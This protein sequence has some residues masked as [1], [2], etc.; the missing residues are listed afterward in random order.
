MPN[1]K[2]SSFGERERERDLILVGTVS[3]TEK[4]CAVVLYST[5]YSFSS[6]ARRINDKAT[7]T[8]K[9]VYNINFYENNFFIENRCYYWGGNYLLDIILYPSVSNTVQ[10]LVDSGNL[11]LIL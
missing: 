1:Y 3:C 2:L 6:F 7:I 8:T 5:Q 11:F 9:I 10:L 4:P